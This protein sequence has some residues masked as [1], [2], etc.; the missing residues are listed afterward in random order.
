MSLPPRG[1][2]A[3]PLLARA[4]SERV[5]ALP[6]RWVPPPLQPS[7]QSDRTHGGAR[8]AADAAPPPCQREASPGGGSGHS[9]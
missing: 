3:L 5:L 2:P 9:A 1:P 6:C 7:G 8:D 4:R